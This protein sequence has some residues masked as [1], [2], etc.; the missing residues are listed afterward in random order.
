[1]VK[2]IDDKKK[3]PKIDIPASKRFVRNALW[4]AAL[5]SSLPAEKASGRKF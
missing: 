4:E 3:A 5:K 2:E 1:M